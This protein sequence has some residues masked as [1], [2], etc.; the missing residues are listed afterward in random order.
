[1][2]SVAQL[3]YGGLSLLSI[4][5]WFGVRRWSNPVLIAWALSLGLAGGMA[6]VVWG[7]SG[8]AVGVVAGVASVLV[9]WGIIWL[10]RFSARRA[11]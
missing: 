7:D 10:L 6:P 11:A 8:V 1:L 2:K 4:A 9:A 5:A 3:V